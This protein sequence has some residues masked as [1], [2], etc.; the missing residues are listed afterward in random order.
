MSTN[1][2]TAWVDSSTL[3][4]AASMG[5]VPSFLDRAITY[6]KNVI[7][8]CAGE[9]SYNKATGVLSWSGALSFIFT[10]S[11]GNACQN[12][13]SAGSVTL[14]DGKFAYV[15]LS[16]TNGATVVVASAT[17]STGSASNFITYNRLVLAYRDSTTDNLAVVNM[18]LTLNDPNK[19]IQTLTCADSVTV[20]WSKGSTALITLDRALTTFT[21]T[22]ASALQHKLVLQVKQYAGVGAIAFASMVKA[23]TDSTFPVSLSTTTGK[24]DYVGFI[25]DPVA[26]EYHY[27]GLQRGF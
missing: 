6:L 10:D 27:V 7:I 8:T 1:F 3:F 22:G 2:H 16:E 12:N 25:F 15:D 4:S 20:D 24:K 26:N 23:G 19:I 5:Q 21:F 17:I 18:H 14:T 9:I 13:A 11:S